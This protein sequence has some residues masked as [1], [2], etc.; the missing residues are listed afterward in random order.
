MLFVSV[1]IKSD[2]DELFHKIYS[3]YV[4]DI[5]YLLTFPYRSVMC[6][7]LYDIFYKTRRQNSICG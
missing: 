1:F 5:I 6:I 2:N 3:I 7:Y 4:K